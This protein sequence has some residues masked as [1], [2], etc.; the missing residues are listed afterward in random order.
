MNPL[1]IPSSALAA[2]L[3][4]CG[5]GRAEQKGLEAGGAPQ[6]QEANILSLREGITRNEVETILGGPGHYQFS[7]RMATNDYFCVS[8]SFEKPYVYY[9]FLFRSNSLVKILPPPAFDVE[10]ELYDDFFREIQKPC[11]AEKRIETVLL[12]NK[13]S[14][15]ELVGSLR[16]S[17]SKNSETFSVLPALIITAPLFAI[18]SEARRLNY[19]KNASLTKYFDP[20]KT[21]LGDTEDSLISK[22][23]QPLTLITGGAT[24]TYQ[25]GSNERLTVNPAHRFSGVAVVAE[26]GLVT[27]VFCHD[28][29]CASGA[30][31]IERRPN[32]RYFCS[33]HKVYFDDPQSP[34]M[35]H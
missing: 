23:G 1:T 9:Y 18:K 24:H 14:P 6:I 27:R 15:G 31:K 13:L 28:F 29:F 21:K 10:L 3:L 16:A 17:L 20:A 12:G 35:N 11:N 33:V 32:P 2:C 8:Y 25:F 19:E 5:C 7:A 4:L 22:Y 34:H 26:N 30:A